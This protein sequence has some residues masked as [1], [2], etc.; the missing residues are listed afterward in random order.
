MAAYAN[1]AWLVKDAR[2]ISVTADTI[3]SKEFYNWFTANTY[4]SPFD[5]TY[6]GN[7]NVREDG[8]VELL[9]SGT[10][11]F[12]NPAVIDRFMVGGGGAGGRRT[13]STK[14]GGGGGGGGYT[15]TTKGL[16]IAANVTIPITI[17]A[18]GVPGS[19]IP[20]N[21]RGGSTIWGDVSVKGG[22]GAT[23]AST[24]VPYLGGAGGSGGGGG[25]ISN[26]DGGIGGSDGN[27][28][29]VGG[30]GAAHAGGTGQGTTTREFAEPAGKLYAGGGGGGRYMVS[31]TPIISMGGAGG[32]GSGAWVGNLSNASQAAA[33]GVANT[34]GG[35]GGGATNTAFDMNI[36]GGSGGSGI[37]CFRAAK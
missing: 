16:Q 20:G 6:T 30:S 14:N 24:T 34:G 21:V 37:I 3:V 11:V 1:G 28:G 17:G 12:L 36:S 15:S 13:G 25:T 32:G 29:E 18:G 31:A 9:T 5:M 8:V 19:N 33:A 35:G 2:L 22:E 4:T 23:T 7:Y 27:D 10:L 26:S